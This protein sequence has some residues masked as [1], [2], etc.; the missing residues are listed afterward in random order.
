MAEVN[1]DIARSCLSDGSHCHEDDF[2]NTLDDFKAITCGVCQVGKVFNHVERSPVAVGQTF[3]CENC[4]R[5]AEL[6]ELVI[7][8][9]EKIQERDI[10]SKLRGHQKQL[11]TINSTL[12]EDD[13]LPLEKT[14]S[15]TPLVNSWTNV[16]R[17]KRK[18]GNSLLIPPG[19][20]LF[21]PSP[22]SEVYPVPVQNRFASL[23]DTQ[24]VN[25]G[26]LDPTSAMSREDTLC[27]GERERDDLGLFAS[28]VSPG[29]R[30]VDCSVWPKILSAAR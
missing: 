23:C 29:L 17:R 8:L 2:F 20:S 27:G 16:T 18:A 5:I 11:L 6:Q 10:I 3:I 19:K 30:K 1:R 9:Q 14:V 25:T 12:V 26:P 22:I 28:C 4:K 15:S 24:E 13:D 21:C 7:G